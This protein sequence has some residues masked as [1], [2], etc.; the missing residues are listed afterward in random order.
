MEDL[1]NEET[2]IEEPQEM[3]NQILVILEYAGRVVRDEGD[4]VVG[5]LEGCGGVVGGGGGCE[6]GE[7]LGG[8]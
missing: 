4:G 7:K 1:E 2:I 3:L 6:A 5:V 8:C